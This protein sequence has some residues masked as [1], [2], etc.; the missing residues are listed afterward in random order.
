MFPLLKIGY[1]SQNALEIAEY[2]SVVGRGKRLSK[3]VTHSRMKANLFSDLPL[4]IASLTLFEK[5][6]GSTML[7]ISKWF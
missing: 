4:S 3:Y 1:R 6:V 5:S 7:L 2:S